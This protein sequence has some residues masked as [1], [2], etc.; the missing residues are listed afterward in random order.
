VFMRDTLSSWTENWLVYF[1]VI[2][3]AFVMFSPNGI[4][5]VWARLRGLARR[6]RARRGATRPAPAP[7]P[8]SPPPRPT[9]PRGEVLLEVEDLALHFG[10]LAAVD[11]VSLQVPRGELRSIIG[12]N[13]AGKTTLFN[14]LTGLLPADRGQARFRATTITRLL[15]HR[16]VASGVS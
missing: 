6:P 12:P 3:V 14:V 15:P 8:A 5:G 4:V 7:A 1:G 16:I 9:A 13:G 2:F 11:G 10:A